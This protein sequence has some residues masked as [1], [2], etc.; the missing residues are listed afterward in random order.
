MVINV[1]SRNTQ[2]R[3]WDLGDECHRT[4]TEL[5]KLLE[6]NVVPSEFHVAIVGRFKAGKSRFVNEML[7]QR[8]AGENTSP[9]T[10]A[11]TIFRH[12]NEVRA[13]VHFIGRSQWKA[14][15]DLYNVDQYDPDAHRVRNWNRFVK[16]GERSKDA[17]NGKYDLAEIEREYVTDNPMVRE[18]RLIVTD[19]SKAE[20]NF[21]KNLQLFTVG[22]N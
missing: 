18:L 4:A 21:R 3:M 1:L 20:T 5:K 2:D 8:L 22:T 7:G 9:E 15:N 6:E 11:I 17:D 10:A 16:D 13:F 14:L 12:G 19:D